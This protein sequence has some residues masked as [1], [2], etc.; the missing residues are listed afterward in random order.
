M[1]GQL[2][3]TASSP[4]LQLRLEVAG[5]RSAVRQVET[6]AFRRLDEA[7]LVDALRDAG[8]LVAALGGSIVGHVVFSP[9]QVFS[10]PGTWQ[11][12]ALGPLAVSP[13]HQGQGIGAALV[14]EGLECCRKLDCDVV[15]VLAYPTYYPRSG[16]RPTA[17]F[18]IACE[19]P[20]PDD[21]FMLMELRPNAVASLEG[22]VYY[23]PP[24]H[25]L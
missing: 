11:A 5:D 7:H 17:P 24:F 10:S 15:F 19:F 4:V 23:A 8:S 14:R 22:T 25:N 20:V 13:E 1:P 16:F 18:D 6:A 21:V 3:G 2:P 12:L 9:V